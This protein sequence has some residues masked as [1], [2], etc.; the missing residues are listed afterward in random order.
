MK[1]YCA[2][3]NIADVRD[4]KENLKKINHRNLDKFEYSIKYNLIK[5]MG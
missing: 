5:K 3:D 4:V 1:Y 2:T